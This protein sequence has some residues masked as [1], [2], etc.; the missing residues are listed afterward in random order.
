MT[1]QI[2]PEA[3]YTVFSLLSFDCCGS[4]LPSGT[5]TNAQ[6]RSSLNA[7]CQGVISPKHPM[8]GVE[9]LC[10]TGE[11][12]TANLGTGSGHLHPG[13]A[14]L[15]PSFGPLGMPGRFDAAGMSLFC[16]GFRLPVNQLQSKS[17]VVFLLGEPN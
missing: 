13:S 14:T 11:Q 7:R 17:C 5:R 2:C 3:R 10:H 1:I 12:G 16:Q 15:P 6:L 9:W 8:A 4:L